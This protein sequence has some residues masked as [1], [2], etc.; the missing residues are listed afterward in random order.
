[1]NLKWFLHVFYLLSDSNVILLPLINSFVVISVV[2]S[3][4]AS[5]SER[6]RAL[7]TS[8]QQNRALGDFSSFEFTNLEILGI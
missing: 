6:I 1:M 4:S 5:A 7:G 3:L 2:R 8:K